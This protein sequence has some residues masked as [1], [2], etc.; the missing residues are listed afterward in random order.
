MLA[1]LGYTMAGGAAYAW[2]SRRDTLG[3]HDHYYI[4]DEHRAEEHPPESKR[5][6]AGIDLLHSAPSRPFDHS[7]LSDCPA[8]EHLE[9]D[10]HAQ[11]RYHAED[12]RRQH[13][14]HQWHGRH[15]TYAADRSARW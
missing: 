5:R 8:P 11:A 10:Q 15:R 13:A 4:G 3:A 12:E 1:L 2:K 7:I 14:E 9:R 6:P